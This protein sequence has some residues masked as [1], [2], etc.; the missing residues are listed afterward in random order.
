MG[1]FDDILCELS[2]GCKP[3]SSSS[4][5]ITPADIA[6]ASREL[7]T[8]G[9]ISLPP[10]A[11]APAGVNDIREL[12]VQLSTAAAQVF[13]VGG[14]ALHLARDGV[15]PI[16]RFAVSLDNG[17]EFTMAPGDCVRRPFATVKVRMSFPNGS[18][19]YSR[20]YVVKARF[21]VECGPDV[22]WE[23]S[24]ARPTFRPVPVVVQSVTAGDG[25]QYYWGQ[26]D[27]LELDGVDVAQGVVLQLGQE[28]FTWF[29]DPTGFRK[30]RVFLR[31]HEDEAGLGKLLKQCVFVPIING[32]NGPTFTLPETNFNGFD[33][34]YFDFDVEGVWQ[35]AGGA[36]NANSDEFFDLPK[37]VFYW[38]SNSATSTKLRLFAHGIK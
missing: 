30:I 12:K 7:E 34:G 13:S 22:R 17:S 36:P 21:I 27:P 31:N 25:T 18:K 23:P 5:G 10:P 28:P 35:A 16:A 32:H 29:I 26:A 38:V 3:P 11:P 19:A 9:G 2:G 24:I 8:Q 1:V 37:L 20:A 6:R 33:K 15:S 4:T 14:N